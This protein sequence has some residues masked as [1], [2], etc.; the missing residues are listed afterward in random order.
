MARKLELA[1]EFREIG[2]VEGAR[3]LLQ[4]VAAKAEGTLK[5]RAQAMLDDMR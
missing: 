2:D 5:A 1:D 4:E 3:D